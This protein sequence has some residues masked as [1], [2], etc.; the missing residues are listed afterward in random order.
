[1]AKP[2]IDLSGLQTENRNPRTVNIDSVP[3]LEL[4]KILHQEDCTVP[5]A[6]EPCLPVI[7]DAIEAL[8]DRVRRGGRVF[9]IGAGTSGR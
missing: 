7:A 4:C 9:Y 8:S 2:L 6:V 3:V 5:A 1:M